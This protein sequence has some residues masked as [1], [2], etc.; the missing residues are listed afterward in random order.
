M[1]LHSYTKIWLHLIWET[2]NREKLLIDT[3]AKI[4][5][6]YLFNYGKENK[7]FMKVNY[8]NSEHVHS[9]IDLPSNLSV[10]NCLKLFKGASSH[11]VNEN[12]LINGG[13]SWGRGYAVFSVSESQVD[14][15]VL[16]IKNQKEHHRV[17]SFAEE[18]DEFLKKYNLLVNR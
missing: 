16:Y 9:L 4:V 7:I 12:H 1:S 8:V 5:S 2:H 3:A 10:E 18:Y 17:K 15:V 14:K 13:F 11:Y 6:E